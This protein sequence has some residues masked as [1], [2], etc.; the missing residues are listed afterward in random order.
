MSHN[1]KITMTKGEVWGLQTKAKQGWRC[2]YVMCDEYDFMSSYVADLRTR[3]HQMVETIRA[4]GEVDICHLQN[5]F[6]EMYDKLG[7]YVDCP[8]CLEQLTKANIIVPKCGHTICK[9]CCE[10]VKATPTPNCPVCRR[11]Y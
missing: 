2:Y 8:I 10:R 5:V 7:E 6:I 9:E 4:G 11:K 1:Q 3:N